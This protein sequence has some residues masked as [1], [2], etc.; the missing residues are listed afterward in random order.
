L[1]QIYLGTRPE[2]LTSSQFTL[3]AGGEFAFEDL[4]DRRW[5]LWAA[6]LGFWALLM[7]V[8]FFL[9]QAMGDVQGRELISMTVLAIGALSI[10]FFMWA[11]E[12]INKAKKEP[13]TYV[14]RAA[15][16][17][18]ASCMTI[19]TFMTGSQADPI[20]IHTK[21]RPISCALPGVLD[22]AAGLAIHDD[23]VASLP[24]FTARMSGISQAPIGLIF[25]GS[26]PELLE[27][28][29]EA[30]WHA[31][32]RITPRS[33]LRAFG[34]G[35]MN[36]PYHCAPVFPSFLDGRLN[37]VAFQQTTPGGSSR[38]RHHARFWLTHFTCE[39]KQVWVATAS[40]DAGVGIGRLFPM[41][42][43]HIDPD[44]DAERDYITRSLTAAGRLRLTQ[45]IRVTEPMSGRNSA[46]DRFYT[47][48]MAFVLA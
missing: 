42:I 5:P 39:G 3:A 33:A 4:T 13:R 31:A 7:V 46:G 26:G 15:M 25:L 12:T 43:H 2:P 47:W 21:R 36:R 17:T 14:M 38:R 16:N 23:H 19:W 20:H 10:L 45:E 32:E 8:P 27:A 48:G 9:Y 37:D 35:V 40:Y 30:G 28:F 24:R 44:I 1:P 22:D 6:R 41:P 34:R 29:S 18:C 11:D